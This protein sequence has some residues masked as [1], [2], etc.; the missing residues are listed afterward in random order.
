MSIPLNTNTRTVMLSGKAG[1]LECAYDMPQNESMPIGMAVIAH[2][3]PQQGGSMDNKVVHTIARTLS[4]LGYMTWRFNYRGVS[5]S[6]G[7]WDNGQGETDDM[8]TVI[9][10]VRNLPQAQNKPLLLAGFSFGG[11]VTANVA[12]RLA[13]MQAPAQQLILVGL[14]TGM[15]N[16][17]EVPQSTLVVHGEQDEI[18]PL[19][20]VMDWCRSQQIPVTVIPGASHFFHG[21]LPVLKNIIL[22]HRL[23][24]ATEQT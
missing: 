22:G 24:S 21:Q 8:L 2:P 4:L 1:Q 19:A 15:Y 14:A 5:L 3:N 11:Y 12:Q 17:P 6:E 7:A 16:I 9:E 10:H 20:A 23:N 18:I 13:Q